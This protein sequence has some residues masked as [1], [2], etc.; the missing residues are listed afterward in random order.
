MDAIAERFE[1]LKEFR[2]KLESL[3]LPRVD[4]KVFGAVR[5][6]VHIT[7]LSRGAAEKWAHALCTVFPGSSPSVRPTQWEA[8]KNRGTCLL[9]TMRQGWFV[10]LI[11]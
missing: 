7:T 9:P 1:K 3:D 5:V 11:A 6:N 10:G 8:K 4:I 2:E